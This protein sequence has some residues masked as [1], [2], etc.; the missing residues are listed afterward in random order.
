MLSLFSK[1]SARVSDFL[2]LIKRADTTG[3]RVWDFN[4]PSLAGLGASAGSRFSARLLAGLRGIDSRGG[5]MPSAGVEQVGRVHP[6]P[7]VP[8]RPYNLP[9]QHD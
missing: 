7:R 9:M 4:S 5:G 6:S 1:M 3:D 8:A 2:A